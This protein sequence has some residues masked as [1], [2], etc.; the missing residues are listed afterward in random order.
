MRRAG[1]PRDVPPPLEMLCLKALWSIGEGNVARVRGVMAETKPL[2][3]TTVMT[4]LERLARKGAVSRR[5]VGRAF[6]YAP[7]ISRD[8]MRR[9]ALKEFVDCYFDGFQE[10]LTEFLRRPAPL[11]P[12]HEIE[13]E[14]GMDAALL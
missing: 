1:P 5:K 4:L 6:V 9:L 14:T 7:S 3:Y 12:D 8:T 13:P 2:A 11:E 10:K